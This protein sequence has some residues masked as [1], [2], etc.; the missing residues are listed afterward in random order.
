MVFPAP[1]GPTI[2]VIFPGSTETSNK[3]SPLTYVASGVELLKSRSI[4]LAFI[5]TVVTSAIFPLLVS[6]TVSSFSIW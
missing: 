3:Y 2:V 1:L 4:K 5:V 6:S